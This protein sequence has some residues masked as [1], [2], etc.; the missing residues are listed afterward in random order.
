MSEKVNRLCNP[1]KRANLSQIN[2]RSDRRPKGV[3]GISFLSHSIAA[4]SVSEASLIPRSLWASRT[5]FQS[6][7]EPLQDR[8][9]RG[10][11]F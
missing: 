1:K 9:E 11:R 5:S 6:M 2:V 3:R 4:E 10:A 7:R 8:S